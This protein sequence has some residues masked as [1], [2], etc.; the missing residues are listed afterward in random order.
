MGYAVAGAARQR[1]ADVFLV[2]GPTSLQPPEG[3]HLSPV[4]SASEMKDAVLS[5]YPDMNI[6]IKAAAVSDF[7][8]SGIASEKLKKGNEALMLKLIPTEDILDRLGREKK[9][10]VLV[11]FA[12]ETENLLE[13][14]RAK[15]VR[16]NLDL[17]VAN[18]VSR[19]VF[20]SDDSAVHILSPAG[21]PIT[22]DRQSKISIAN[23]VLDLAFSIWSSRHRGTTEQ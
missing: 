5:L 21:E 19:D 1:G 20:G 13:N 15:L 4:R 7:R 3:V 18:D 16:K 10:Q 6:V 14:A 11:G 12:A 2:S 8:P 9:Q 17:L 22:L 23:Q